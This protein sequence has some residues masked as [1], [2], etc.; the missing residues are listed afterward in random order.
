MLLGLRFLLWSA[1]HTLFRVRVMGAERIPRDTGALIIANHVSYADAVLIGSVTP[2]WIRFL[3]WKPYYES[4]FRPFFELL[5]AI[6]ISQ[7]SPRESLGSLA[8][9]R[10]QLEAGELI[11]IF[12]EGQLTRGGE[13]A[14]FRSGFERIVERKGSAVLIAPIIPIWLEGLWGHPLSMKGGD[15]LKSWERVWRPRVTVWIGEPIT[16]RIEPEA[17]RARLLELAERVAQLDR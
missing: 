7:T 5:R 3:L 11:G 10:K 1:L 15:V 2:R 17:L 6:P 12:P 16:E 14:P 8:A 4:A 9:A 13:V